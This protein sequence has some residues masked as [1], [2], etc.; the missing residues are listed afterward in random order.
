MICESERFLGQ[1]PDWAAAVVKGH[2]QLEVL[3]ICIANMAQHRASLQNVQ[4]YS[5][6]T[7]VIGINMNHFPVTFAYQ[8]VPNNIN[9]YI[10]YEVGRSVSAMTGYKEFRILSWFF[11]CRD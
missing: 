6:S 4:L 7:E 3:F 5:F 10:M 8:R 9:F 1:C 2:K 11:L